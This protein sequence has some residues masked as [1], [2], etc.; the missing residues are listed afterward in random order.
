MPVLTWRN[1]DAPDFRSVT[2]A[3]RNASDLLNQAFK[4]ASDG[5]TQFKNQRA[6]AADQAALAESLKF[7]DPAAYQE[8]L[9]SGAIQQQNMSSK[10]TAALGARVDEL[11]N[12]AASGQNL[13]KGAVDIQQSQL[14]L[15][16]DPIQFEQTRR[17]NDQ[18]FNNNAY[19]QRQRELKDSRAE[20]VYQ[21]TQEATNQFRQLDRVSPDAEAARQ[22]LE[23][24]RS[25]MNPQSFALLESAVEGKYKL[26]E[27]PAYT[28]LSDPMGNAIPGT[29]IRPSAAGTQGTRNGSSWDAVIGG[30]VSPVPVSTMPMGDLV[31]YGREVLI[32]GNRGKF[33]N[34]PDKGSSAVGAFQI[35]GQTLE[36]Y[37]PKVLG[38]DWESQPFNPQNQDKVAEAIFNDRK[39]GN[40]KDTWQGLS[41][42]TPGY[43]KDMPWAEVRQEINKVES[44]NAAGQPLEAISSSQVRATEL[45]GKRKLDVSEYLS[46]AARAVVENQGN[47]ADP[48]AAAKTLAEEI[49]GDQAKILD[50]I[51]TT[52]KEANVNPATAAA[53]IKQSLTR[54]N[55][56]AR[57]VVS[58]GSDNV[59]DDQV[60]DQTVLDNLI[61]AS[62]SG[63]DLEDAMSLEQGKVSVDTVN[64]LKA[65]AKA[66]NDKLREAR[67][68]AQRGDAGYAGALPRIE[69]EANKA[70]ELLAQ[71]VK[72]EN[73]R[74]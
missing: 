8:A 22:N 15:E 58:V 16:Q 74:Q 57:N 10:G 5:L 53:L 35:T 43:Y 61:E 47:N 73:R 40:L 68:R 67:A 60:I 17:A 69:A 49:G 24:L 11:L 31:K 20:T 14:D 63:A 19:T 36:E 2:D 23:S 51:R 62:K 46:G 44:A 21:D 9:R 72:S 50:Q 28:G 30:E 18:N 7:T 1:V 34:P 65:S 39:G 41:N 59:S 6:E 45:V 48:F 66:A 42:T 25:T 3:S 55:W 56:F 52:Q 27:Q 38:K 37:A 13:Q 4:S 54:S 71:A 26:S 12:Q 64:A 32:P 29:E 70:A 33:G